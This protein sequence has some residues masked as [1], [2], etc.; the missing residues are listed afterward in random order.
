MRACVVYVAFFPFSEVLDLVAL[1][2]GGP[3]RGGHSLRTRI[4]EKEK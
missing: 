4:S 1:L 2:E 3:V